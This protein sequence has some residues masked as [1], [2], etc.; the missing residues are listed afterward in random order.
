MNAALSR[1]GVGNRTREQCCCALSA[2]EFVTVNLL[3]SSLP[4][5]QVKFEAVRE[6]SSSEEGR[7]KI[8]EE[9]NIMFEKNKRKWDRDEKED[10]RMEAVT[11]ERNARTD[12]Y[13]LKQSKA[14]LLLSEPKVEVNA[15]A[16]F[17]ECVN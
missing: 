10:E 12:S 6:G 2:S 4:P 7:H 16:L 15:R 1:K 3:D 14:R 8:T 9:R 5:S 11:E 13:K 17:V